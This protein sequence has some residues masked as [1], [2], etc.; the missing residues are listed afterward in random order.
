MALVKKVT[1][2]A[3]LA[4]LVKVTMEA[5]VAVRRRAEVVGEARNGHSCRRYTAHP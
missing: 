2:A 5:E 1:D 4:T 3:G